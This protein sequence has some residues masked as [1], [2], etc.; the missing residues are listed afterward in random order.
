M[1][2]DIHAKFCGRSAPSGPRSE[3]GV[4][5]TPPPRKNLL[6]KSPVKIGLSLW[7]ENKVI[8]IPALQKNLQNSVSSWSVMSTVKS[9]KGNVKHFWVAH[10]PCQLPSTTCLHHTP[11]HWTCT[12]NAPCRHPFPLTTWEDDARSAD[13]PSSCQAVKRR[14]N[15]KHVECDRA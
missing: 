8:K 12:P 7:Y 2:L 5:L 11:C 14:D 3:G 15:V 13:L 4:K 9:Q 10:Q 6:S 1:C